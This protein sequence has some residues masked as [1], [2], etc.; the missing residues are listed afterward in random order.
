MVEGIIVIRHVED[1]ALM[2]RN[3]REALRRDAL[4]CGTN[5]FFR[6]IDRSKFCV[7]TITRQ[8]NGLRSNAAS[9][10]QHI[11]SCRINGIVVQNLGE[12]GCLVNQPLAF[13]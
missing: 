1:I 4:F 9:R 8:N 5:R 10:F 7:R 13:P 2:K 6:Y 12:R 3:I 11:A